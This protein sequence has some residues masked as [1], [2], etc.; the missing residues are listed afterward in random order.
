[1][2]TPTPG[3]QGDPSVRGEATSTFAFQVFGMAAGAITNIV[4]ART[5]GPPGKG[6]LTL[7]GSGVF[8]ATSLGALGLQAASVHLIGKGRHSK[9]DIAAAVTVT[10]L[11]AGIP[12][13]IATWLLLPRFQG[14]I[15]LSPLMVAATALVVLPALLRLNLSGILLGTGRMFA[16]NLSLAGLSVAWM[17]AAFVLL[18]PLRGDVQQA[19]LLWSG[20]Q[21][22]GAVVTIAAIYMK[23]PPRTRNLR[24]CLRASLRFGLQTYAANLIWIMV[25][26]VDSFIL[27][28]Y[29][30]AAEVG[31]YS[32]AVLVAEV[33]LH[34]PR[35]LSL[36]LTRRFA[37]GDLLPTAHL[38]ARACRL[39]SMAVVGIGIGL[40][41]LARPVIPFIFG[42][43]FASSTLPLLWLLPGIVSLSIASPLSLYLV[44]QR[45]KPVWTG[46]SALIA[47]AINVG[48]NLLWIPRHGAVGAA[49]ASSVA[50][51][52]HAA[53]ISLLFRSETGLGW[54]HLALPRRDDF[55]TWIDLI[56]RRGS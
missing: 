49:W 34:L 53:I 1:V 39:G 7:L 41:L 2:A 45:G 29:R 6:I 44:Q 27:A 50:Y 22:A 52:V 18:V 24:R 55:R 26:R 33:M 21:I 3:V 40:A 12:C 25:L 15:P 56:S 8:V 48:L 47:L 17:L 37:A 51:T 10:G 54:G 43:G 16:Y 46:G 28:A 5:L 32:V 31:I 36:V 23:A 19:V 20:L 38:A 9:E 11:A 13:A 4:I 14:T 35:S 42:V 30:S